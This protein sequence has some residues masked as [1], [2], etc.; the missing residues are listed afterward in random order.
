MPDQ[1]YDVRVEKLE[2][3]PV[4][5]VR[6]EV[7]IEQISTVLGPAFAAVWTHAQKNG[8][9]PNGPPYVRY[10]TPPPATV[11][12]E[13]GAPVPRRVPGEG[14]IQS[15]E[16]PEC[17]AAVVTYMGPYDGMEPAYKAIEA[18]MRENG[19]APGGPA[20]EV[21]FTDPGAEPDSAKWRTDIFWPVA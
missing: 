2:R 7:P 1:K 10:I 19:R 15:G 6:R 11:V 18:W 21:Y 8:V 14:D 3:T 17:E 4:L 16:L 12:L 5:F 13:A 20:W 9:E